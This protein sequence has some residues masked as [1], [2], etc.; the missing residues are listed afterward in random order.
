MKK[1]VRGVV[2][3]VEWLSPSL[4]SV[5]FRPLLRTQY[6][7]GQFISLEVPNQNQMAEHFA[8][9]LARASEQAERGGFEI[10]VRQGVDTKVLIAYLQSLTKGAVLS[11]SGPFGNFQFQSPGS[12][13]DVVFAATSS[14]LA[15]IRAMIQSEEFRNLPPR[16]TFLL[17][18]VRHE[19]EVL[20]RS[21]F[22]KQGIIVIPCVTRPTELRQGFWGRIQAILERDILAIDKGATEYYL[23][24]SSELTEELARFLAEQ[25]QVNRKAI[26]VQSTEAAMA[27]PLTQTLKLVPLSFADATDPENTK[28]FKVA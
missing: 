18:G 8:V 4:L 3:S 16:R 10:W 22:E 28:F 14:G 27:T 24:G 15:P 2:T 20:F 21:E 25:W 17:Y 23:A 19:S 6:R 7:A 1:T 26:H 5:V 12:G 11:F 13:K 9:F